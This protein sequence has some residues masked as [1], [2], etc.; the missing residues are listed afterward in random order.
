MK[1]KLAALGIVLLVPSCLS[2]KQ[3]ARYGASYKAPPLINWKASGAWHFYGSTDLITWTRLSTNLVPAGLPAY[4]VRGDGGEVLLGWQPQ[5]GVT[6]YFLYEGS[7]T[8]VYTNMI[9]C[10]NQTNVFVSGLALNAVYYFSILTVDTNGNGSGFSPETIYTN[11][12]QVISL[13]P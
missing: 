12:P 5:D 4:F 6:D 10:G 9:E 11:F 13:S 8:Q 2:L 1:W 3:T 7:A